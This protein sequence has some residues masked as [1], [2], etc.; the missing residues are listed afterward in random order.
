MS[1]VPVTMAIA[2]IEVTEHGRCSADDVHV[3]MRVEADFEDLGA[4]LGCRT[5]GPPASSP[6]RSPVRW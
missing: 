5:S 2:G 6:P 1:L 4:G 3:G